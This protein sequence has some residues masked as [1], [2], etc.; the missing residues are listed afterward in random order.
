[1]IIILL[2][3]VTLLIHY[4]FFLSKILIGLNK[5]QTPTNN[6][7]PDELIS[8]I[9]PFRNESITILRSLKSIENLN[10]PEN[11]FEVIYIDDSSTDDSYHLLKANNKRCNIKILKLPD[12][13]LSKGNKKRAVQY[14]IEN[15]TGEIIVTTDADCIHNK[16]WL[17]TLLKYFDDETVFISAPVEFRNGPTLFAKIQKL[18]FEGLILAGAGLIG[19][20]EPIICNGANIS[21]RKN[22]FKQLNGYND[23]IYLSSGDDGFLMQKIVRQTEYKIKFCCDRDAVVMTDSN[24]N[25]KDFFNQRNR[26]ASKSLFYEDKKL[27]VQLMLIFLFYSGLLIQPILALAGFTY[28]WLIFSLSILTKLY[29]EF[30]IIHKGENLFFNKNNKMIFLLT[31]FFQV[32]YIVIA[33]LNGLWGNFVWKK[34]KIKR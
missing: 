18:E 14:G 6:E 33:S 22:I 7:L 9:I 24:R 30:Q 2:F 10:Y 25:V 13:I 8:I 5:L 21:Y 29:L 3:F 12:E 4:S 20:G 23:N 32:P 31:E 34:R 27:V 16:N 28:I 11:K 17:N 19:Y 26:W 15:S 1:M